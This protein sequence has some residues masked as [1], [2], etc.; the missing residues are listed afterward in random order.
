VVPG[1]LE[2]RR[3]QSDPITEPAPVP[4]PTPLP[5]PAPPR[6]TSVPVAERTPILQRKASETT[7]T[8]SRARRKRTKT[9]PHRVP[10]ARAAPAD[11]LQA[12]ER[13]PLHPPVHRALADHFERKGDVLRSSL[14]TEVQHA[15]E[16]DPEAQP[17]APRGTLS[18][19]ELA[20]LRHPELRGPAVEALSL[21]GHLLSAAVAKPR[22]AEPFNMTTGKGAP[23]AGQALLDV[24]RLL[25]QRAPDVV[26]AAEEGPPFLLQNT[27]PVRLAVG[28]MAVRKELAAAELR[29]YAARALYSLSPE[30]LALRLL[31]PGQLQAGLVRAREALLPVH[32][33]LLAPA[34]VKAL[35]AAAGPKQRERFVEVARAL[36]EAEVDWERLIALARYTGNRAGLVAS[37]GVAP[38]LQALQ[39]KR[40]GKDELAEVVKFAVSDRMVRIRSARR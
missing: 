25:G 34:A 28:R 22:K 17:L 13:T 11:L 33:P 26:L 9:E 6:P 37:G 27:D 20:S 29:F 36:G 7:G 40:A 31:D 38:T 14:F 2:R 24:V 1:A 32:L 18:A 5:I 10:L 39:A 15:L 16:G 35:A 19:T 30:L 3:G 12:L 4:P 21:L 23:A 8:G